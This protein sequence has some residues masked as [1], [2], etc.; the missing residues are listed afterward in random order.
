MSAILMLHIDQI[1]LQSASASCKLFGEALWAF[2]QF[3]TSIQ[4]FGNTRRTSEST[5]PRSST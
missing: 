1:T 5:I 4:A 2:E 3:N